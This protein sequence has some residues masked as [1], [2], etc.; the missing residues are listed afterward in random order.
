MT[1]RDHTVAVRSIPA[2]SRRGAMYRQRPQHHD[3]SGGD[4]ITSEPTTSRRL[5]RAHIAT[6][7]GR[8]FAAM[9]VVVSALG[10]WASVAQAHGS[11]TI[12]GAP[13]LVIGKTEASG[14]T[15]QP[16]D[17]PDGG[18]FW[19][20]SMKGGETLSIDTTNV[21]PGCG[22]FGLD[23]FSPATTDANLPSAVVAASRG[24]GAASFTAPFSGSWIVLVTEGGCGNTTESYDYEAALTA[25]PAVAA[26]GATTIAAAPE[27]VLGQTDASGWVNQPVDGPDGGEFWRVSMKGGETLSIDTTN[28]DP[29]CGA[30]GLDFFSPATTDAN[31]PSAVVAASRG[32]GAASFTAP[33]SGSWIVLVTEGG[34]GNTTES[35]DYE[36]A[37]TA[38]PAV[39]ATG[40]T[41]IAAAP[42]LV[43][44]QTDAS[45]WVNQPVDGTNG[46]EFW[47]ISMNAGET[48][49]FDTT[50]V[51][52]GCGAFS[53]DF[54]SPA[55]T[56]ANFP[57]A[58]AAT[59]VGPGAASFT[60]PSSGSWIVLVTE[61]GCGNTTESYDYTASKPLAS[62]P[63]GGANGG[64]A[65]KGGAPGGAGALAHVAL[66]RQ[67]DVVSSRGLASVEI[68]CSG[69]PCPG[70]PAAYHHDCPQDGDDR[71]GLVLR[72]GHWSAQ[73]RCQAHRQGA[74]LPARTSRP[75]AR[76]DLRVLPRGNPRAGRP[77]HGHARLRARP[78]GGFARLTHAQTPPR[79]LAKRHH[80]T[81]PRRPAED[82]RRDLPGA[83][84]GRAARGERRVRLLPPI[85]ACSIPRNPPGGRGRIRGS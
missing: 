74:P 66:A 65:P 29:G 25:G 47:K 50:N 9:T 54:Y 40:A 72:P 59:T 42:E 37:L 5:S 34:C 46:G 21:D 57:A 35:Y 70:Q 2:A 53:V 7:L 81:D 45:G 32:G 52:P 75:A 1:I 79:P 61:G 56:D 36:A 18:E 4:P 84:D 31:L 77:H 30:F 10:L 14:W 67:T 49:S 26:T 15:S 83:S 71:H 6:M 12:A 23:F 48:L 22:A 51:D 24:G 41:T 85:P 80:G 8:A 62:G 55:T 43:L 13:E 38:G 20:V 16:V 60:A 39:A 76:H 28:V 63:S 3:R 78:R 44:G 19:R 17:G 64:Q 58:K 27:L 69:A 68:A 82:R 73:D 11:A 33:F